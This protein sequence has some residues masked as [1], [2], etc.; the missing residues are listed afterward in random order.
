MEEIVNKHIND[1]P[2]SLDMGTAGKGGNIKVYG[3]FNEPEVFKEKIRKAIE[4][5]KFANDTISLAD[6]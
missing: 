2:D 1:N 5:R 6:A 3:N 4:V